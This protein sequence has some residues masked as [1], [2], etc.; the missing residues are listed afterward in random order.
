[1]S[2]NRKNARSGG[3]KSTPP[4]KERDMKRTISLNLLFIGTLLLSG[5]GGIASA[6]TPGGGGGGASPGQA[7]PPTA[8]GPPSPGMSPGDAQ[9]ATPPKVDDKKFVKDAAI[10]GMTEVELGK[11]AAQKASRDEVKQFAQKMVDDHTKAGEQLKQIASKENI[12]IADALDSKH[13]SRID[14][15]SKLSGQDFDK[16]YVKDQLKDHQSDV[17]DFS[18]EA[19]NG[20]NPNVKAFASNTLPTLQEHLDLVKNLNKSQKEAAKQAKSDN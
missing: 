17:K 6:Q 8:Q 16:A 2:V 7:G 3:E 15:L 19:Q 18:A 14:K 9:T 10:G 4:F 1:M 5:S 20:T 11:L 12:Q 13:Q